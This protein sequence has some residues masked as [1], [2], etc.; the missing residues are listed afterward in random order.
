VHFLGLKGGFG[1]ARLTFIRRAREL[2]FTLDSVRTLLVLSTKDGSAACAEIHQLAA[3]HLA[4]VR[5]K[6]A[7]L[8]TME[9]VLADAVRRLPPASCPDA[10]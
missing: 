2:G 4:E 5:A 10:R 1:P 3:G 6:I 7:D 8:R 9:R